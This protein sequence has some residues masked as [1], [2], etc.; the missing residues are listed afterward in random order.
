MNTLDTP[1]NMFESTSECLFITDPEGSILKTNL[2]FARLLGYE[3]GSLTGIPFM[4]IIHV[5]E[6]VR[7]F[8]TFNKLHHLSCASETPMKISLKNRQGKGF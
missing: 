7:R 8:I 4:D 1:E 5:S 6:S 2:S 3:K